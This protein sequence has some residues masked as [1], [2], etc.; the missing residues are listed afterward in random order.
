MRHIVAAIAAAICVLAMTATVTGCSGSAPQRAQTTAKHSGAR[1]PAARRAHTGPRYYLA[2][3]DSLARGVQPTPAGASL[4]SEN[5][6]ADRLYA[7]LRPGM[8]GLRLVK[9]GCSGETSYTMVHGGICQYP[10]GSQL[11]QADAFLRAHRRHMALVTIDIGAN[12]PNSCFIGAPLS[13]VASCMT[14]RVKLT[15]ADLRTILHDLRSAGG[16][17]LKIIGMSYYVPELAGWLDGMR[18]KEVAVLTERLV[19]GYNSLLIRTY[20]RYH[21]AVA[22]VFSAFHS[23]D[24]SD[25]VNLPG[26]G[27]VPRNVATVCKLTWACTRPPRGPN[28]HANSLGYAIIALAFLLADKS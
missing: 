25:Q 6:Y 19:A 22:G 2:L 27:K 1:H 28:E 15:L 8:P 23:S 5:G 7:A 9:L 17:H 14:S 4:S 11:A 24:F 12:D 21:A 10:V 26:I 13:K 18:G 20:H 16:R 3:G